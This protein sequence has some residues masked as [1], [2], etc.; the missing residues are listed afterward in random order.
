[1]AFSAPSEFGSE[2]LFLSVASKLCI[3]SAGLKSKLEEII[4]SFIEEPH[5]FSC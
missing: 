4:S 1:M 3:I 2:G 5:H